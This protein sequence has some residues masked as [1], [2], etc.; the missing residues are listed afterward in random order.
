MVGDEIEADPKLVAR[1]QYADDVE[2]GLRRG[3]PERRGSQVSTRSLSLSISR[4]AID[5][6]NVI[7]VEYRTLY[8]RYLHL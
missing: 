8:V 4:S 2:A 6:G 1:V 3:R 5:P 7:P